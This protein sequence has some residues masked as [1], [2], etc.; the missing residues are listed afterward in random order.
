MPYS[1]SCLD[2]VAGSKSG[3]ADRAAA[4]HGLMEVVASGPGLATR[5]I[6]AIGKTVRQVVQAEM[7]LAFAGLHRLCAP[8]LHHLDRLEAGP[9][10]VSPGLPLH[11]AMNVEHD[12]AQPADEP[13]RVPACR[14]DYRTISSTPPRSKHNRD[15]RARAGGSAARPAAGTLPH[16]QRG[17]TG[18]RSPSETSTM[19]SARQL[20]G[21]GCVDRNARNPIRSRSSRGGDHSAQMSASGVGACALCEVLAVS[22]GSAGLWAVGPMRRGPASGTG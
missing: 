1:I 15:A 8:V 13:V 12:A 17:P 22:G 19:V 10:A 21:I 14:N 20:P 9:A 5:L 11:R 3:E 6:A 4:W 7:E 18:P 16:R 2:D